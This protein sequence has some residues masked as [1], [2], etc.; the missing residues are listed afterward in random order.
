ME[1]HGLD[2][3]GFVVFYP[4]SATFPASISALKRH[5]PPSFF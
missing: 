5:A 4:E 1:N 3:K 2:G